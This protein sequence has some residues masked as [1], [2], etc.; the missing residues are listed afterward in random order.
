MTWIVPI[1]KTGDLTEAGNWRG[2]ALLPIGYKLFAA[3]IA[4]RLRF[5]LEKRR[6]LAPEQHAF[7][8]GMSTVNAAGCLLEALMR[9]AKD[10][11]LCT[12][13]FILSRH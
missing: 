7:R 8:A 3:I 2:I 9:R 11:G 10:K 12:H 6:L 13:I 4:K 5:E 1:P